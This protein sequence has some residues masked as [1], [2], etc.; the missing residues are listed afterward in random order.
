MLRSEKDFI[1][2]FVMGLSV[3]IMLVCSCGR[4]EEPKTVN[5][6]TVD[7]ELVKCIEA[8]FIN[9]E[10]KEIPN[11]NIWTDDSL[12]VSYVLRYSKY[13]YVTFNHEEINLTQHEKDRIL[14]IIADEDGRNQ[15]RL[16]ERLKRACN[17]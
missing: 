5:S 7:S 2:L 3:I 1:V 14:K 6:K 17:D 10:L 15:D 16:R 11:T 8:K 4:V 13:V 12:M 9:G